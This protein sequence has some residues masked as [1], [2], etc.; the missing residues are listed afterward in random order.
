M[1]NLIET[2]NDYYPRVMKETK[3]FSHQW[4]YE[5][6]P[7]LFIDSRAAME[8]LRSTLQLESLP[9]SQPDDAIDHIIQI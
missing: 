5:Y 7:L 3:E 2:Q 6:M 9:E 4:T 8:N 1:E